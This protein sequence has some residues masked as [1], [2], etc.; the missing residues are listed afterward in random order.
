VDYKKFSGAIRARVLAD[1][2]YPALGLRR[3]DLSWFSLKEAL[4]LVIFPALK[5][6]ARLVRPSFANRYLVNARLG[7]AGVVAVVIW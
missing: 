5:L 1:K 7:F 3:S 6:P 4:L 2:P